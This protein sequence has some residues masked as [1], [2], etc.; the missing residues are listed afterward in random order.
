VKLKL[1]IVSTK[2]IF[3]NLKIGARREWKWAEAMGPIRRRHSESRRPITAPLL[4]G[5]IQKWPAALRQPM[6]I[7][8]EFDGN[9]FAPTAAP[10]ARA[11]PRAHTSTSSAP[12]AIIRNHPQSSGNNN[13]S[14]K[15]A[16]SSPN[17]KTRVTFLNWINRMNRVKSD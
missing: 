10:P 14:P 4:G 12:S 2:F 13:T 1:G 11:S 7:V 17:L 5:E 9:S 6:A 16:S 3:R 8:S 15:L